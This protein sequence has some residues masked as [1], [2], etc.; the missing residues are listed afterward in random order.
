MFS[1]TKNLLLIFSYG[2]IQGVSHYVKQLE[3]IYV[4]NRLLEDLT[5]EGRD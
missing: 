2:V 4:N 3:K 5:E 1:L